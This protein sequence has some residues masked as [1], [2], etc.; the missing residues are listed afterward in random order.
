M[1][2]YQL[3]GTK[4]GVASWRMRNQIELSCHKV[5]MDPATLKHVTQK[6]SQD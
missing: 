5:I 4:P 3:H 1:E 6:L 2:S